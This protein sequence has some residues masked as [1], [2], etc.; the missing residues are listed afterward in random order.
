MELRKV[1]GGA[2]AGV[3]DRNAN[4]N[5]VLFKSGRGEHAQDAGRD[6]PESLGSGWMV[7]YPD[8]TPCWSYF[9]VGGDPP[10]TRKVWFLPAAVLDECVSGLWIMHQR[11]ACSWLRGP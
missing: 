11:S 2:L 5:E 9:L 7:A 10:E 6:S 8:V 4:R 3:F 1:N